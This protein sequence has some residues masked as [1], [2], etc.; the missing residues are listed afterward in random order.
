ML[1]KGGHKVL[2]V[3]RTTQPIGTTSEHTSEQHGFIFVK[4][5]QPVRIIKSAKNQRPMSGFSVAAKDEAKG[6]SSATAPPRSA[7]AELVSEIDAELDLLKR[8]V[9]L[10]KPAL[11]RYDVALYKLNGLLLTLHLVRGDVAASLAARVAASSPG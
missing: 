1:P 11:H 5:E 4:P 10:L 9:K 2:N 8:A 6:A 3:T 7:S